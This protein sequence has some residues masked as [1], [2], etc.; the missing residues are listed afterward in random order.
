MAF[1][2]C[3]RSSPLLATTSRLATSLRAP[4]ASAS[5]FLHAPASVSKES[6]VPPPRGS[7]STPHDLL[8]LSKRKLEAY[9]SKLG[10]WDELFT[11]T[12]AELREAGMTIKERRYCLWFLEKYRQGE[13]P[14]EVAIAQKPKKKYR[15]WGPKVQLGKRIR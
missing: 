2:N 3:T 5:R 10:T 9:E 15:G 11:K 8:S 4:A 14:A 1:F 13:D 6:R 7:I 12:G